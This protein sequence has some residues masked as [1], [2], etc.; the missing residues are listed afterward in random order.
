MV[1]IVNSNTS[2]LIS[3][4]LDAT[5]MRQQA[6]SHNIANVN[7]PGYQRLGVSFEGRMAELRGALAQGQTPSLASLSNYRPAL[8]FDTAGSADG[9][10]A[11]DV[12]VAKLSENTLHQQALLKALNKHYALIGLAINGG[13]R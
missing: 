9:A 8:Q 13:K 4:A 10:V 12:E 6:I 1:S 2:A 5:A 7:T 11:L 3:L